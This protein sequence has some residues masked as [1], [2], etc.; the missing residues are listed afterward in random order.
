MFGECYGVADPDIA[1]VTGWLQS[2]GF[3]IDAVPAGKMMIIFS[4]TAGQV[5]NTFKTEIHNLNVRGEQTHREHER[6][7]GTD[8]A[9]AGDRR[10]P[11]AEQLFPETTRPCPWTH[12]AGLRDG[13]MARADGRTRRLRRSEPQA[14]SNG[15][16]PL[17]TLTGADGTFWAVGP[18]DFYTIYNETPLLTAAKPINGAGQTLAI[19]QDSDVN[20]ADVTSFRSQFGLPD[21]PVHAE[22]HA[23][24]SQLH[25]RHQQLLQRSGHCSRR[26]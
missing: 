23:G 11:L 25:G 18:Q 16:S 13:E 9:G 17:I 14:K 6:A 8:R 21:I 24:R 7:A 3:Q 10:L 15:I 19:V 20:P 26:R 22:Q 5:R 4:G 12:P 1:K 2:H